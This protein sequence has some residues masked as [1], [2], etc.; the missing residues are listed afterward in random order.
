MLL[1]RSL[2]RRQLSDAEDVCAAVCD[3]R[4]GYM[5]SPECTTTTAA[6]FSDE[7]LALV[8]EVCLFTPLPPLTPLPSS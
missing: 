2:E 8:C 3:G 7:C 1:L 6:G 4:E 5:D